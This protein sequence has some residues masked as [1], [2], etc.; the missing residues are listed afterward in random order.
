MNPIIDTLNEKQREAV[1]ATDGYVRIIA[2]AGSGKTKTLTHR[3]AYLVKELGIPA[4]N[5][6]CVTFTNK[7]A[8]EM[9][10]RVK[11][12]LN[13]NT[14]F[15]Y[16]CTFHSFCVKVLR[17]EIQRLGFRQN[18]NILDTV[19]QKAVLKEVYEEL[20]L[21]AS[22]G[23]TLKNAI[24]HIEVCKSGEGWQNAVELLTGTDEIVIPDEATVK[25]RIFLTYLK[26]QKRNMSL[27][28]ND[29]ISFTLYLMQNNGTVLKCWSSMFNYIM[30]DETQDNS[31][32]QWNMLKLLS[33]AHKNLF[34]VGDPDQ[35]IYSFRGAKPEELVRFEKRF[36]PCR[37]IILNQ[38]YRSTPTILN[39]ANDIIMHNKE[40]IEKDLYTKNEQT[41]ER[42]EWLHAVNDKD[43]AQYVADKVRDLLDKDIPAEDMAVL[44]RI[45]A[46][47]R[48]VEQCFIKNGIKYQVYGGI[49][50]FERQE[51]KD[52]IAYLT[53]AVDPDN[54]MAF[55]RTVNY[56]S[57]KLGK[58][59]LGKVK[60]L[61]KEQDCSMFKALKENISDVKELRKGGAAE[62]LELIDDLQRKQKQEPI[63][64]LA[65]YTLEKTGIMDH[66][67][68]SGDTE[69]L[70]NL[71]EFMESV[72]NY[73][74]ENSNEVITLEK[75]LQD[76]SLYTNVDSKSKG[77]CI[78]LMTIHQAKGL[79]FPY[80]FI[81][82]CNEGVMPN[83]RCLSEMQKKGLEEERRLMYVAV[84][85]AKKQL[86]ISENEGSY[87]GD[88]TKIPSRFILEIAEERIDKI[89]TVPQYLIAQTR[90][91]SRMDKQ[92]EEQDNR[93]I[94]AGT[95]VRHTGFG[96]GTVESVDLSQNKCF[97]RFD[98]KNSV[99]PVMMDF[100]GMQPE[101]NSVL[102]DDISFLYSGVADNI[103]QFKIGDKI[104]HP[105]LG[106]GE[107]TD[108][109]YEKKQYIVSIPQY[110]ISI[111]VDFLFKGLRKRE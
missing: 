77:D 17:K 56:P 15:D 110:D 61:A 19:D 3:F 92:E 37:T 93:C 9:R 26:I 7:A 87:F 71:A 43:E 54:D 6:L 53:M 98:G 111:P 64:R 55:L 103:C 101:N 36:S 21:S 97:V 104:V 38:N 10:E 89:K 46:L 84:T 91:L 5:I 74:L 34:V 41:G 50:F 11:A 88:G 69:R 80:V 16:V 44:F 40:R 42:I 25:D 72:R 96:T 59:F 79:E 49:R 83:P 108:I 66:W 58:V 39:A 78:K 52:S 95:R 73:E 86:F 63:S 1:L 2:G 14:G 12:L 57:R 47:S 106:D 81:F 90:Q 4:N 32:R 13:D 29:L 102:S 18:F 76:I 94:E 65:A 70:D 48:A 20:E 28:F 85:R 33:S 75:Y 35:A 107:I 68:S 8:N 31:I 23:I 62:Y 99:T 27:D 60:Q 82:G 67:R 105:L 109:C 22:E 30:V 24:H 45:S 100:K 51:I